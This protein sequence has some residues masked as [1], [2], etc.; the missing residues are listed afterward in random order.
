MN[1]INKFDKNICSKKRRDEMSQYNEKI[2]KW[3]TFMLLQKKT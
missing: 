3:L 2:Q 1:T